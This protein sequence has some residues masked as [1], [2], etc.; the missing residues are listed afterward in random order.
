AEDPAFLIGRE[1][2]CPVCQGMAI[3][4]SPATMAQD[5]M[6]RVRE[7]LDEGKSSDEIKAYFVERYGEWV[8]LNP[9][10]HGV[11][12]WVWTLPPAFV[13]LG[14]GVVARQLRRLRQTAPTQSSAASAD[15]VAAVV[16]ADD[17]Y[18]RAIREEVQ[19]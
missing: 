17:P 14:L 15:S 16:S 6:K 1:L 4:E 12:L 8:L 13:L 10:T 18:L 5:M 9:P 3:A 7:M 2:R 11:S 19:R